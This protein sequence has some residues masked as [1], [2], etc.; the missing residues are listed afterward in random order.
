MTKNVHIEVHL[1]D[2]KVSQIFSN[3]TILKM[4]EKDAGRRPW[5]IILSSSVKRSICLVS[6][7]RATL[8]NTASSNLK[9]EWRIR[10]WVFRRKAWP[11]SFASICKSMDR[12]RWKMTACKSTH[13]CRL[14]LSAE[15]WREILRVL[16]RIF[17]SSE[18]CF[19]LLMFNSGIYWQ[20]E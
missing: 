6:A 20:A 9:V 13:L 1:K 11:Y 8:W 16:C 2:S 7:F 5:E 4:S 18:T 3:Y 12:K 19:H 10:Q 14:Q 17:A 15:G